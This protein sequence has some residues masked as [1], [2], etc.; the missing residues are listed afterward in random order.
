MRSYPRNSPEA[1]ARIVALVLISDGQ[2]SHSE[3]DALRQLGVEKELGLPSGAFSQVLVNLCEDL[4]SGSHGPAAGV[5][6]V[7]SVT[8]AS[9]LAEVDEPDLQSRVLRLA[10]AA[11]EADSHLADAEALLVGAALLHWKIG[12]TA[13]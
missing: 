9:M 6:S 4:L 13:R 5:C 3:I 10:S 12:C 7:D 8:L 2:V 11:A 1:A